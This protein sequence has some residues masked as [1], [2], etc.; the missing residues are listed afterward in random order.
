M[1]ATG[2][3]PTDGTN[4]YVTTG[5]SMNGGFASPPSWVG[6]DAVFKI[7]PGPTFSLQPSNYYYPSNWETM[8][9]SDTDLGGANAVLFDMPSAP[10]PHLVV[11]LGKD[12]NLYLLNRDNLGGMGGELSITQVADDEINSGAAVYTTSKGTYVAFRTFGSVHGC[13]KSGNL[14]VAKI[15]PGNPPTASVVWCSSAT[16]LGSPIVTTTDGSST[17]IVWDANNRLYGYDGDT[18]TL[19]FDGSKSSADTMTDKMHYFN[20]PIDAKG[21]IVVAT[22]GGCGNG[23]GDG[24]LVM[25]K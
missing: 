17:F 7:A 8:D 15:Q 22:C 20:A 6:G 4:I 25:F 24:K 2:G 3:I 21:R 13:A 1:W 10:V 18:G 14:G 12:G 5:N 9:N 11:A 16:G 23:P 19:V